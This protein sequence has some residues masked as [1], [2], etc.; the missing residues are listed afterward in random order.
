MRPPLTTQPGSVFLLNL[1]LGRNFLVFWKLAGGGGTK[2]EGVSANF[3]EGLISEAISGEGRLQT[4]A[5]VIRTFNV[6][7]NVIRI[8]GTS[9]SANKQYIFCKMVLTSIMEKKKKT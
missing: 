1:L 3:S 4:T 6:G 8:L 9:S 5:S 7:F 2:L